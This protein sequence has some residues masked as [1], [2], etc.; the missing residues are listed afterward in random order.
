ME[1]SIKQKDKTKSVISDTSKWASRKALSNSYIAASVQHMRSTE[2]LD[3]RCYFITAHN[4]TRPDKNKILPSHRAICTSIYKAISHFLSISRLG[5]KIDISHQDV[6]GMIFCSDVSGTRSDANKANFDFTDSPHIH[7]VLFLPFEIS[8]TRTD[9]AFM[10]K[11]AEIISDVDGIKKYNIGTKADAVLVEKFV[12]NKPMWWLVDYAIKAQRFTTAHQ[13]FQPLVFPYQQK[14]EKYEL[15]KAKTDIE[16]E[17][18]I[19]KRN[20]VLSGQTR[21]LRNLTYNPRKFYKSDMCCDFSVSHKGLLAFNKITKP[22]NHI[23]TNQE[24]DKIISWRGSFD[25]SQ[26]GN[27]SQ[28]STASTDKPSIFFDAVQPAK[29]G[30]SVDGYID[31]SA[32]RVALG[33][34]VNPPSMNQQGLMPTDFWQS[35]S[36]HAWL[37]TQDSFHQRLMY[38]R[39]HLRLFPLARFCSIYR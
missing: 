32:C 34:A 21:T 33:K 38:W 14:L 35:P 12:A 23:P 3:G 30:I 28:I 20:S 16:R 9:A 13:N 1:T 37:K 19:R 2:N 26:C 36:E 27:L 29:W 8:D 15:S 6:P 31:E 11:L 7:A 10:H 5:E 22:E 4:E 39:L 25:G 17:R 24:L 18:F